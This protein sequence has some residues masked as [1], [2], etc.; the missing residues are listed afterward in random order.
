[1]ANDKKYQIT[2]IHGWLYGSFIWRDIHNYFKDIK[3]S[4]FIKLSGYS[5]NMQCYDDQK[6]INNILKSQN[7]NDI[8]LSYSY[9][10]SLILS[11]KYLESCAGSIFLINPFFKT[12]KD[13]IDK[14]ISVIQDDINTGI[15]KFTYEATKGGKFH[16]KNYSILCKLLQSNFKPSKES[17]CFGLENLKKLKIEHSLINHS[18]KLHI[19]QSINDNVTDLD[20]FFNFER[21]KI[22][23]YRLEGLAHYPFFDFEKIYDIIKQKI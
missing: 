18:E 15:K 1:M 9:S 19:I 23:T 2:Y 4:N 3:N 14:L 22:N 8:L 17:L 12:K 11:S 21:Q 16:K 6:I 20:Y 13:Y 5:P 7:E 10:A